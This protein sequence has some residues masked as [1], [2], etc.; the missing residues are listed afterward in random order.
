MT[1]RFPETTLAEKSQKKRWEHGHLQIITTILP[2]TLI[3]VLRQRSMNLFIMLLD[4]IVPPLALLSL[5]VC[6]ILLCTFSYALIAGV[7]A[8]LIVS[9]ISLAMFI[10]AVFLAWLLYGK[11]VLTFTDLLKI[12]FYII[13][14][15]PLYIT[16]L[17]RRQKEWVKTNRN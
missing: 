11:S 14:K 6:I 5:F 13:G 12:P 16:Y 9:T 7:Y 10:G 2:S 17:F 8:P 3:C 4:L 1:I 15:I